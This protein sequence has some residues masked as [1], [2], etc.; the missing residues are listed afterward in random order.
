M[1]LIY[2]LFRQHGDYKIIM[3]AVFPYTLQDLPAPKVNLF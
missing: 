3:T 2:K 1:L